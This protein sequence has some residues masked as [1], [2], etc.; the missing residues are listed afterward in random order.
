MAINDQIERLNTAKE[1][2]SEAI[3]EKGV[4]IP[5]DTSL[6]D[7]PPYIRQIQ[8]SPMWY[9]IEFDTEISSPTCTR[10]GN[11]NLHRSLPIQNRMKGCLLN[12]DGEVVEYLNPK[13]WTGNIRDGSRG[14]VMIELPEHYRKFETDGTKRRVLISEYPIT[15]YHLVRKRYVSAY[16]ATVQ[17]STKKLCSVV[18]MDADYRGGNNNAEWDG[19][20]RTLLGRPATTL[21]SS[22]FRNY[23]RNRKAN[24]SEWNYL[25]YDIYK[26]IYWL[27]V[28]EYATL[29]SQDPFNAKK[30]NSGYSQ[31]GL[32]NGVTDLPNWLEFNSYLPFIP[33]GHTDHLGNYSGEVIYDVIKEDGTIY[34][35]CFVP[36]YRGIENPFGHIWKRVDGINIC[37]SPNAPTSD[38]LSK[39]FVCTDP[40]KFQDNGYDGYSYVGNEART[41]GYVKE[42]IFGDYGEIIPVLIGGGTTIYFCDYHFTSIPETEILRGVLLGGGSEDGPIAGLTYASSNNEPWNIYGT[43]GTRL[44]FIPEQ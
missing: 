39:V 37:V 22:D 32:G 44:C 21:S 16:E 17:R 10:I 8:S 20:H 14:Q 33:C 6:S 40:S 29:N 31:G 2:I 24:S 41:N 25:V 27:F 4:E 38:G 28:I 18:N 19:S 34:W 36:R 43:I 23:A 15:G 1:E 26:D 5:A 35:T 3:G 30:D 12:D 7:Y 13:D 11:L 42:V 9:G